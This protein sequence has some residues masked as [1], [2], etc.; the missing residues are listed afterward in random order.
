MKSGASTSEMPK[1]VEKLV[2]ETVSRIQT[3]GGR[4]VG[5]IGFSQGTKVVA[6][7]LRGAQI[8]RETGARGEEW[9]G[10]FRFGL[11]VCGS[12][13]PPL[14]P[15]AVGRLPEVVRRDEG[16]RERLW[17]EKIQAPVLHVQ[18]EQDEWKWAGDGLIEGCFEVAEGKS[19][20]E[21]WDMGHHYPTRVEESER[22][23][24]WLVEQLRKVDEAGQAA[25]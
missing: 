14:V 5:V 13:P 21:R 7:L 4:V 24:D 10:A 20:V 18:G 15:G 25:A 23:R 22:M 16:E 12:Y 6:G 2:R 17:G 11:S 9:L 1:E 19:V 8:R 3:N